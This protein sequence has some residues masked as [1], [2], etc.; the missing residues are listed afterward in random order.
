MQGLSIGKQRA[1]RGRTKTVS[2][3]EFAWISRCLCFMW[4]N[5]FECVAINCTVCPIK[6]IVV[7]MYRYVFVSFLKTVRFH[8][9]HWCI[10]NSLEW[11]LVGA[12]FEYRL[13]WLKYIVVVLSA[14]AK[15]WIVTA[16]GH[17]FFLPCCFHFIIDKILQSTKYCLKF[18]QWHKINHKTQDGLCCSWNGILPD[19]SFCTELFV[20]TKCLIFW[21][22]K[23]LRLTSLKLC[24]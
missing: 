23:V 1:S 16:L 15:N 9:T 14:F 24:V 6:L 10:C 22:L 4:F 13:P 8:K 5:V 20:I 11:H 18:R 7:V 19:C 2:E 21:M 3:L 17:E 12:Y